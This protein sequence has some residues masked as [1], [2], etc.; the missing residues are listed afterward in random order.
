MN[1]F[2]LQ[3]QAGLQ[4]Y[5][6]TTKTIAMTV[7]AYFMSYVP[8]IVYAMVG[9]TREI[10][11]ADSWLAFVAWNAIF[12]SSVVNPIIFF[13]RASRFRSAFKQFLKDPLGSND[14]KGKPTVSCLGKEKEKRKFGRVA[15]KTNGDKKTRGSLETYHGDRRNG[16]IALSVE[17]LPAHLTVEG[18]RES[19]FVEVEGL[20]SISAAVAGPVIPAT[21]SRETWA[22]KTKGTMVEKK[23]RKGSGVAKESGDKDGSRKSA[24]ENDSGRGMH[25]TFR[26]NVHL[27]GMSILEETRHQELGKGD[28][29]CESESE[30]ESRTEKHPARVSKNMMILEG[31]S[32]RTKGETEEKYEDVSRKRG[33]E[34]ES[35]KGKYDVSTPVSG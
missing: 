23:L 33:Y 31:S 29:S 3:A 14:F 35:G 13:V 20:G 9:K 1:V 19:T 26:G 22:K 25:F 28:M 5:I 17:A 10:S 4:T 8:A 18:A 27:Q 11:P 15:I 24:L 30:D 12:L 16:I 32:E 2:A 34:N 6:K 7:A 21:E